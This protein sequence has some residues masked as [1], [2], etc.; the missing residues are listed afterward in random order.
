MY[1]NSINR[2]QPPERKKEKNKMKT[3]D[4]KNLLH[5]II[6]LLKRCKTVDEAI[7]AICS[8]YDIHE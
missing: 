7:K 3:E 5:L 1:N 2:G 6:E 4:I 8:A